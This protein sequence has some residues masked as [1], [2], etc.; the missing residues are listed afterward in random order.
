MK[1]LKTLLLILALTGGTSTLWAGTATVDASQ[2]FQSIRGFGACSAWHESAYP[3]NLATWYW[4]ATGMNGNNPNGI[5]LSIL[6][7]HI[8]YGNSTTGGNPS[9]PGETAVMKQAIGLGCTQIWLAEWT[10]PTAYK[11][12]GATYGQSNNTFAGAASG[13][14]NSADTGYASY[15]VTYIKYVNSQISGTQVMAVSPQNE[16]D[17]NPTY[18]SALWNAGQFSVFAQALHSA[19]QTAGLSTQ[20]MIPESFKDDKSLAATAMNDA[21]I[22]GYIGFIGNHLYGLN[23]STPYSLA[24][25]GFSH[26]TTQESWETEMSDVSGA[27][28]DTSMTSGLQVSHWVQQ[29]IVDA[30]MNAYHAWWLYPSSGSTNEALI[31]SDN[32]STKKL[33]CLGN[34]SRFVRPG[35]YR[36]G[37][38]E[39]PSSG[40]SL[41]AFKN[42]S[43]APSTVVI[44]AINNNSSTT[45]QTF[46]FNGVNVSSVTP[47]VTDASNNLARQS[48]VAVSGN[49]FT[50]TLNAKS[51]I[52]FV[53]AVGSAGP[54][55]TFTP[56]PPSATPSPSPT[57]SGTATFTRTFTP[58][59]TATS[60]PSRTFTSIPSI[61]PTSTPTSTRT[62]TSTSTNT[63]TATFTVVST[64]TPV[65]SS[66]WRVNAGGSAYTDSLGNVWAADEN[67]SGGTV[68]TQG[69][70]IAGTNDSTLYDSQRYG[71]SFT[72]SFNVPAG[73]YQVTLKMAEAYSGDFSAG[74]RVFNVSVNGA[75]AVS[76]LD[77]FAQVGS[78]AADDQVIN[79]VSPSGGM[80]TLQFTAVS[81]SDL[82][83]VVQAIQVIPMP[84]LPTITATWTSSATATATSTATFTGTSTSTATATA[85][86]TNTSTATGTFTSIPTVELSL[87]V[88]PSTA[89]FTPTTV[90]PTSTWTSTDT[91]TLT[92]VPPTF[93]WTPVP[94]TGTPTLTPT[95]TFTSTPVPPTA[96][97]TATPTQSVG[98]A[99]F[100]LQLESV[101]TQASTNS[102]HPWFNLTN[103]GTGPLNLNT[104]TI[105]YWFT[106]ECTN[107][108]LQAWVDWAGIPTIGRSL[109]GNVQATIQPTTLGGQTDYLQ[110]QFTGNI[111]L[112]PGQSVQV[113]SRFNKSDWSVM[114]QTNDWSYT[115]VS[116]Y[117]TW[118]KI[119]GYS[120]GALVWGQEPSAAAAA[121]A[122]QVTS[123]VSYPNPSTGTGTTLS[124]TTG[125]GMVTSA[126]GLGD[127]STVNDPNAKATIRVFT[128][129]GRLI[130]ST[131]LSG[132][133]AG[134][135]GNHGV[136]WDER[137][138]AGAPLT[139]GVYWWSVT[140][141]SMGR[142]STQKSKIIILR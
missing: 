37:A 123:A 135:T 28:N 94:P 44:V 138:L 101:T 12:S 68:I 57:A 64:S 20:I 7:C 52:T 15:L 70:T 22:S 56:V 10:P 16:P 137:D 140:L 86:S 111:S 3:S 72:Y 103:T 35:Y 24:S 88:V 33:W 5:G 47:W 25:A 132:G 77:L 115:A 45:S 19:L 119:T 76:N 124:F 30:S 4:D 122:L 34:W 92:P 96:T 66:T 50:Y 131:V 120:N 95:A 126:Q 139:N 130:W 100:T 38:T 83:A 133:S 8:P 87:T 69:G 102:P 60:T 113:Q 134:D 90:P 36:M 99:N 74:S 61:S 39:A 75:P 128:L 41:S 97:A 11:T 65:V 98:T 42:S 71:A 55:N 121:S 17:W 59:S 48:A 114:T 142:S 1:I 62:L 82:N 118:T 141:D 80:I 40:V 85:T 14:P 21:T 67:Y 84:V 23:G 112:A 117:T 104:V 32:Q 105:R 49:S 106:C 43:S 26:L 6:R 58:L 29:C 9:D 116:N 31:G 18:E 89:T 51:V 13:S 63:P 46:S 81:G 93:T 54:T 53:G 129:S 78:N 108:T 2:T 110:I 27:A 73:S 91:A 107:Q 127:E 125:G 79:N 109:S 136:A